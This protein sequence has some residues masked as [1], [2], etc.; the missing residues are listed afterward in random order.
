MLSKKIII[1]IGNKILENI[2][3]FRKLINYLE[4]VKI[5]NLI[6]ASL[7]TTAVYHCATN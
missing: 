6:L 3:L 4:N 1:N 7:E 5:L 2:K